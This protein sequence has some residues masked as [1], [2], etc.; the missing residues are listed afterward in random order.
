MEHTL[1]MSNGTKLWFYLIWF[2]HQYQYTRDN[3]VY[4]LN[5][6]RWRYI[7][8]S[9]LVGW[10]HTQN[11]PCIHW[12]HFI[13]LPTFFGYALQNETEGY[14]WNGPLPNTT[15]PGVNSSIEK[16]CK[17]VLTQIAR[18]M[19]PTW[20]PPGA[21]NDPGGP[22]VGPMNFAIWGSN[23]NMYWRLV[24]QNAICHHQILLASMCWHTETWW[25]IYASVNWAIIGWGNDLL[26]FLCQVLKTN[27]HVLLTRPFRT[28]SNGMWTKIQTLFY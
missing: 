26:A 8:A 7:V 6:E 16:Y 27:A 13:H 3:S 12:I 22:H 1:C 15:Q 2:Y 21:D 28:K 17:H 18:F 14:G 5:N 9:P 20:G 24:L 10:T 25:S 4:A 11:N 23:V 19:G